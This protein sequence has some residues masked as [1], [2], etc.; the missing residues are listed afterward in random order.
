MI[1][2]MK[3]ELRTESVRF[4]MVYLLLAQMCW[5]PGFV[6]QERTDMS[7]RHVEGFIAALKDEYKE[8]GTEYGE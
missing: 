6:L 1:F 8:K 3:L 2:I 5:E 4:Q 7:S